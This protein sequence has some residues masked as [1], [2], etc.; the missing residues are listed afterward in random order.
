VYVNYNENRYNFGGIVTEAEIIKQIDDSLHRLVFSMCW[1]LLPL[2]IRQGEYSMKNLSLLEM[3]ILRLVAEERGI[4]LKD[5]RDSF[6]IPNSTLTSIIKRFEERG[7]ISRS[8]NPQDGRS[9]IIGITELGHKVNERH[10]MFDK[11]IA[12]HFYERL[13]NDMDAQ[14]FI[15]IVKQATQAPLMTYECIKKEDFDLVHEQKPG[16]SE[17]K[18]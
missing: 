10:R 9:F 12:V 6:P 2:H 5:I 4:P 11:L 1:E 14:R 16:V 18:M 17:E 7:L 3:K 15:K 8:V 13:N